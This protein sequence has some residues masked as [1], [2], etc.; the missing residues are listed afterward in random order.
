MTK[1]NIHEIK[2]RLSAYVEKVQAGE[3]IVVCKRNVPVA[4]LR[5]LERPK[6]RKPMLGSAVGQGRVLASFYAPMSEEE[7]RLWEH[8]SESDPVH[9]RERR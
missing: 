2:A 1:A 5:P 4:E 8:G 9:G 6:R 7:L 3:T